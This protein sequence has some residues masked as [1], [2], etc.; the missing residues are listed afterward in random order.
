MQTRCPRSSSKTTSRSSQTLPWYGV[1]SS[2][3]ISCATHLW[4]PWI[5]SSFYVADGDS[6]HVPFSRDLFVAFHFETYCPCVPEL[7][8][9]LFNADEAQ[10]KI[11]LYS[12]PL[13]ATIP[14]SFFYTFQD[15]R[16]L[17]WKGLVSSL[18]CLS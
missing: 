3:L 12:R 10:Y 14:K 2:L 16:D 6:L 18:N 4:L 13:S 17:A 1:Y 9:L 7:F 5:S 11:I 15:L 8:T